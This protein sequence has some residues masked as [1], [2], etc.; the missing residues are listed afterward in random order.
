[1]SKIA[2]ASSMSLPRSQTPE[3]RLAEGIGRFVLIMSRVERELWTRLDAVL[4]LSPQR[5]SGARGLA[6]AARIVS[7]EFHGT[8]ALSPLTDIITRGRELLQFR[9]DL[10]TG[11]LETI[12]ASVAVPFSGSFFSAAA[13]V[14]AKL[15]DAEALLMDL[16]HLKILTAGTTSGATL[17]RPDFQ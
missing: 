14:E 3:P 12:G 5:L 1:M 13:R 7:Y 6:S 4:G 8:D 16:N 9:D 2:D 17:P 11:G 10:I 15:A